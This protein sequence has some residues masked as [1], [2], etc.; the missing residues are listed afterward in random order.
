VNQFTI[1]ARTVK[2]TF[3]GQ[4]VLK[5]VDLTFEAGKRYA[6]IGVSGTGKSTLLHILAGLD[7]PTGGEILIAGKRLASFSKKEKQRFLSQNIG[8]VFQKPY[9]IR[10]LSVEENVMMPAL[11]AGAWKFKARKR[12]QELLNNVGLQS[13][14]K[15]NVCSLSGGEQ[16]R[17]AVARAM[18]NKPSFLL[19]DEPTGNL[20]HAT[21]KKLVDL[22]CSCSKKWGMGLIVTSHDK[23]VAENMETIFQLHEGK[24]KK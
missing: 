15:E 23:Y 10:E 16:Q 7:N 8:L 4:E 17:V 24:V 14:E 18:M 11:I 3:A 1:T 9:L 22:L 12:A 2:K 19:A 13:K 21:G 20:D 6:I 5:G